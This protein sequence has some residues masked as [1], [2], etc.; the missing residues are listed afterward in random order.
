MRAK[1]KKV[2]QRVPD[3][4]TGKPTQAYE[5][6]RRPQSFLD[7]RYDARLSSPIAFDRAT[8][9]ERFDILLQIVGDSLTPEQI[10]QAIGDDLWPVVAAPAS[11]KGDPITVLGSVATAL[12]DERTGINRSRKQSAD[13]AERLKR[14]IPPDMETAAPAPLGELE[15]RRDEL[16]ARVTEAR[17]N[18]EAAYRTAVAEATSKRDTVV[19]TVEGDAKGKAA[20]IRRAEERDLGEVSA[21]AERV[22]AEIRA[23]AERE[24]A[25]TMATAETERGIIRKA[26]QLKVELPD[27]ELD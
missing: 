2:K 4:K 15:Q 9:P 5:E 24:V 11:I 22:A 21:L 19:A 10:R 25:T 20:N 16:A 7:E 26:A 3:A 17:A 14:T 18:A 1:S 8:P 27:A 13:S 6:V 12:Y 23:K